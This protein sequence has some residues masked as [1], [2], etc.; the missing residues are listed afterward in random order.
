VKH[1]FEGKLLWGYR[2]RFNT[3][4]ERKLDCWYDF[5]NMDRLSLWIGTNTQWT[6][7]KAVYWSWKKKP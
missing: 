7:A 5:W 4:R 1:Y 6:M 2:Q 3:S